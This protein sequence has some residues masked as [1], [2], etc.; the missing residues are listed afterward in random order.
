MAQIRPVS[1]PS[2]CSLIS[3]ECISERKV[4]TLLDEPCGKGLAALGLDNHLGIC[5]R[6]T[7]GVAAIETN[8]V[9]VSIH[10]PM[11]PIRLAED[12]QSLPR[13]CLRHSLGWLNDI[14]IQAAQQHCIVTVMKGF[15]DLGIAG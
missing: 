8:P 5:R 2:H 3:P 11:T 1:P 9:L 6:K 7:L 10:D 12:G 4:S 13:E 15:N 14:G